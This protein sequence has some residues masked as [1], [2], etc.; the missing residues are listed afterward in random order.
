MVFATLNPLEVWVCFL[1]VLSQSK[2]WL[3]FPLFNWVHL[4]FQRLLPA[5]HSCHFPW[6]GSKPPSAVLTHR[7]KP[8]R[9]Q[10][11]ILTQQGVRGVQRA[12]FSCS[13]WYGTMPP[14]GQVE[15]FRFCWR[16][17]NHLWNYSPTLNLMQASCD[18]VS[19][20]KK[21]E[22]DGSAGTSLPCVMWARRFRCGVTYSTPGRFHRKT[23]HPG[24]P[25]APQLAHTP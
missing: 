12:L 22:K 11:Y 6:G 16:E 1:E 9:K 15:A 3:Q 21:Y 10:T 17:L 14:E 8:V 4:A 23:S 2:R 13:I 24:Q 20:E 7:P 25:A 5:I 18:K 19:F